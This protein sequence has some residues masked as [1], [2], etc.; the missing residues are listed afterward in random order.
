MAWREPSG[1]KGSHMRAAQGIAILA[2]AVLLGSAP[3]LLAIDFEQPSAPPVASSN[4]S[5]APM[6]GAAEP[7]DEG[8]RRAFAGTR[9]RSG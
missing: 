9:W 3:V 5:D 1:W 4:S 8:A 2:V 6:R 7:R